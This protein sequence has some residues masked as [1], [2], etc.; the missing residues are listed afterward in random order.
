MPVY[1]GAF[2]TSPNTNTLTH[3]TSGGVLNLK[4]VNDYQQYSIIPGQNLKY[5]FGLWRYL[6]T[7]ST[8]RLDS[9]PISLLL[10]AIGRSSP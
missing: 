4:I 10:L 6:I 9:L 5:F 3:A 8:R 2:T 1:P 7:N